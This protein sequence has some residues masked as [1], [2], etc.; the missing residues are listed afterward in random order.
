MN[1]EKWFEFAETGHGDS[2]KS[3]ANQL[4]ELSKTHLILDVKYCVASSSDWNVYDG[5]VTYALVKAML[6]TQ[7]DKEESE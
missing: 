1:N 6:K 5:G 7:K 4:N 3:V 2:Y